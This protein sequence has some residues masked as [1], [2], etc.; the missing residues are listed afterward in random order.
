MDHL[1]S[2]REF[3]D[4]AGI[5]RSGL[6]KLWADGTGPE[7]TKVGWA[8]KISERAAAEWLAQRTDSTALR[9]T[10]RSIVRQARPEGGE[11]RVAQM[12]TTICDALGISAGEHASPVMH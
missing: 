5:S 1:M 4:R 7:A 2:I 8:R 3:C 12:A 9:D 10:I 6:Y 11:D